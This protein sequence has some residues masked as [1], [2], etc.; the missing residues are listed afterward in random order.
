[1]L[2]VLNYQPYDRLPIVHFGYWHETLNKWATEGHITQ[3]EARTWWDG[4]P[5]DVSIGNKLGFDCGFRTVIK[6][7]NNLDP[8]FESEVVEE[9]PDGTKHVLNHEGVIVVEKPGATG[10]PAEVDHLLKDRK[11]WEEHYL[12]RLQFSQ[13]R[14][15][16][17][18]VRVGDRLVRFDEGGREF[19][20][21]DKRD[22]FY[23]LDAGSL[24]G[25]IRDFVGVAGATYIY[26]D[27]E[28]LFDEM[29]NVT[30]DLCYQCAKALLESGAK[31]DFAHYWEDVC[32][33][34]GPLISPWV[35][36][37]KVG[38]HYKR[39]SDLF[40]QYGINLVSVDCDGLIDSL[41]PTWLNNG[42]N[43]MFPIEVGT[44][45]ASIGPWREQYGKELRGVGGMNKTMFARDFAAIDAEVERLKPLVEL[46]GYIPC[47][48]HRIASDA[49][50]DNVR[51][52]CDRMRQT[53]G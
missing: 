27:D 25:R 45:N 1:M 37:E 2:A 30:A 41:I 13:E 15:N 10:I 50:W 32:F 52:Y 48:D 4:R 22:F 47:P 24:F 17:S 38:P 12:P 20:Q 6:V 49:K 5:A 51:Y 26:A 46:G 40:H 53:F 36:D 43:I 8:W 11:S 23:G 39:M 28:A 16:R 44:W 19:L 18:M 42:V 9:F 3:E 14:I 35:F 7:P 34:S 21:E 29:I 31:F 33:K